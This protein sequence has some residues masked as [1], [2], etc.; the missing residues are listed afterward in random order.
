MIKKRFEFCDKNTYCAFDVA[1]DWATEHNDAG[2]VNTVNNSVEDLTPVRLESNDV[3][4][5]IEDN[6]TSS[7]LDYSF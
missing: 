1:L 2:I 7:V 6:V 4:S 3:E 5:D